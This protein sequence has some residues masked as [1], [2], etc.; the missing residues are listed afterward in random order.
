MVTGTIAIIIPVVLF[1]FSRIVEWD[2][3]AGMPYVIGE[4]WLYIIF[5]VS[6]A[7]GRRVKPIGRTPNRRT[8]GMIK[9]NPVSF[10]PVP[11]YWC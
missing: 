4:V 11:I 2:T 7:D 1:A 10:G 8:A 3:E 9:L 5:C 6:I